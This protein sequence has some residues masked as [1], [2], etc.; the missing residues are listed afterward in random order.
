MNDLSTTQPLDNDH[1]GIRLQTLYAINE[2]LR[3]AAAGMDFPTILPQL[4][5]TAR[6]ELGSQAGSIILLQDDGHTE[7]V[8]QQ[9]NGDQ[10]P[11]ALSDGDLLRQ[12]VTSW[13]AANQ[14]TALV[15]DTRSDKRWLPLPPAS[16]QAPWSA[17]CAP[18]LARQ[19][20]AG[21]LVVLKSG[22][23]QL[24]QDDARWLEAVANLTAA[25]MENTRQTQNKPASS[26]AE[27]EEMRDELMTMLIHDLQSP[28]S[29]IISSLDLVNQEIDAHTHPLAAT[30]LDI[31]RRSSQRMRN[32]ISSLLDISRLEA[33]QPI[34]DHS[35]V[36]PADLIAAAQEAVL[37]I[38]QQRRI[39]LILD[40][41]P[42]LPDVDADAD[43]IERVLI[44]LLDNA[45][46]FTSPEQSLTITAR[47]DTT[48]AGNVLIAI[49]DQGPGVPPPYRQAIFDKYYRIPGRHSGMG[50]GLGLAFCRLAVEAH[51]GRIWVDE[52]PGGG[53]TFYFTLPANAAADTKTDE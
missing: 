15:S 53:A 21:F 8:W 36:S 12:G 20:V 30:I 41:E 14:Q 28:L 33:G 43:M 38:L 40:L 52:A 31:A 46:K 35:R 51:G 48:N 29:N 9:E 34:A 7:Q 1:A 13:V 19:T 16:R 39:R 17:I 23:F 49:A 5:Q 47:H 25:A 45:L 37:P 4:L 26:Q 32:L 18:L 50:M 22:A 44:N 42:D 10:P 3:A 2:M 6:R 27:L 11:P 24:T